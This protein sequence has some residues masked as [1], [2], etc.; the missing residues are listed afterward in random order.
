MKKKLAVIALAGMMAAGF[1]TGNVQAAEPGGELYVFIA[2]SLANAMEEIQKDF[3]Q[4]YPD[5]EIFIMQTVP[6]RF[7][8]RLRKAPDVIS[9]SR[10]Q[11]NRWMR[12]LRNSWQRRILWKTFWKTR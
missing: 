2:A 10:Q 5:V 7:R 1:T 4:K 6:V 3:N 9:F 12:L 11:R 8:N